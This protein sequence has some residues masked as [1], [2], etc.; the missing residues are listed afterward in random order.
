VKD[1]VEQLDFEFVLFSSAL[2]DYDYIMGLIAKYTNQDPEKQ[3]MTPQSLAGLI[4]TDA[5]FMDDRDAITEYVETLEV[6]QPLDES[7]VRV[8]YE[9]FRKERDARILT[10][11]AGRHG[12]AADALQSFVDGVLSRRIF[13]GERLTDLLAPLNLGYRARTE[14]ELEL[15][16]DLVPLLKKRAGG[17][18][19]SGLSAYEL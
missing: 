2:I 16:T 9:E 19:V 10:E 5:K 17:S 7:Q 1:Q 11:V 15:M 14:R 4:A 13:D 18:D 12:L 8:G 3:E 6:G